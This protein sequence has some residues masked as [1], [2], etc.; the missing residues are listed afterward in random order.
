MSD[1]EGPKKS[2]QKRGNKGDFHGQRLEFLMSK[3]EDYTEASNAGKTRNFWPGLFQE[4][5]AKFDW[6]LAINEEPTGP[7]A[8]N[9]KLSKEDEAKKT[10]AQKIKAWYNHKRGSVGLAAN[11][12]GPWLTRLRRPESRAPKRI[13]DYQFY[14]QHTEF[15]DAVAAKF[16]EGGTDPK[17][18]DRL[19]VRCKIAQELFEEE[20][21]DVKLRIR[22]EAIEEHKNEL[23]AW[24][25]AD[26]GL[27]SLDDE[28]QAEARR[29]LAVVVSPLLD[30]VREH[31][32]YHVTLLAGRIHETKFDLV[33]VHAGKT[34]SK[35]EGGGL[36]FTQWDESGYK[37]HIL[38]QF[39]R[40]LVAAEAEPNDDEPPVSEPAPPVSEPAPPVAK[41]AAPES[42]G[43]TLSSSSAELGP[44]S[45]KKK[46]DDA[47]YEEEEDDEDED[48][49]QD[50]G[51]EA[52]RPR[53]P[54]R[55]R[56]T[57]EER[58]TVLNLEP[59]L[60]NELRNMTPES[61][62]SRLNR[63]ERLEKVPGR[64]EFQRE[65]NIVRNR[66]ALAA[67]KAREVIADKEEERQKRDEAQKKRDEAEKK[68]ARGD[69]EE[70]DEEDEPAARK[71]G[72]GKKGAGA[73][74][75][76]GGAKATYT[77]AP[78]WAKSAQETLLD[79]GLANDHEWEMMTNLWW[80][81][82]AT[83]GF[84]SPPRGFPA[85]HRPP[86][87]HTWI[88]CARIGT[89]FIADIKVF[90]KQWAVWWKTI[91]PGWRLVDGAL[92]QETKGLWDV[93]RVPGANGFLSVLIGLKWWK[94]KSP[95]GG[96][97]EFAAAVKDVSWVLRQLLGDADPM[98]GVE[99]STG[100]GLGGEGGVQ[101]GEGG[102]QGGRETGEMEG[103]ILTGAS[104]GTSAGEG[105]GSADPGAGSRSPLKQGLGSLLQN[106]PADARR[107]RR[108][109]AAGDGVPMEGIETS[110]AQ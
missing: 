102:A 1:D 31:T 25:E 64:Y 4:Y 14:M 30:A 39:M 41:P 96:G 88:K 18:R 42:S 28:E 46:K 52:R 91:N 87:I 9:E 50:G 101:G 77:A 44:A 37:T 53:T 100:P 62:T 59:A 99:P 40:F 68:R 10:N 94:D 71:K 3:L 69:E 107:L 34:K 8:S 17:G 109:A 15:R 60:R 57:Q 20:P 35:K 82:E 106:T 47:D 21:A 66:A 27:P 93:M 70:D 63:L 55:K 5:W 19:T 86:E 103:V 2:K 6:R 110:S 13:T 98:E 105:G 48:G 81:L 49:D 26:E 89:P 16:F 38:D 80:R 22:N 108:S 36:D 12:F 85:V 92:V 95:G 7:P 84:K 61:R 43:A 45:K 79:G 24:K 32:G 33:S 83:T 74:A 67:I 75:S 58:M 51:E 97:E 78:K 73:S 23:A 72:A 104:G 54:V 90:A 56:P 11:P 76:V 65:N 29:R